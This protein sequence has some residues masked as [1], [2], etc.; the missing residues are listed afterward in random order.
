MKKYLQLSFFF[1]F[2]N[3]LTIVTK[4]EAVMRIFKVITIVN[5]EFRSKKF[6]HGGNV[7]FYQIQLSIKKGKIK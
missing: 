4:I 3:K 1:Y 5:R 2:C 7:F 6:L